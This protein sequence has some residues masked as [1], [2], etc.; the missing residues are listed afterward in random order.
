MRMMT[1][2][3]VMM[4]LTV[5]PGA[6]Q[7]TGSGQ[8]AG[9]ETFDLI[10]RNGTVIDGTGAEPIKADVAITGR[11]ILRI[12]DLTGQSAKREIN[13]TGL[14]VAPGFINLH[15]H[16]SPA[17]LSTAEN[18]LTQ[19]V[20]TEL[21]NADGALVAQHDSEPQGGTMPTIAWR[22]GQVVTDRH[23]I[24]LPDDLPPGD[25]TLIVGIYHRDAPNIRLPVGGDDYL[26]L[27]NITVE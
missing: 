7:P 3:A 6:S 8:A 15:S 24:A 16:A 5:Q 25:Y 22:P 27:S 13:A 4:A 11:N 21:L 10:I 12:G 1:A 20:T 23:G 2:T 26:E 19:G 9:S 18:M 14:Y 17:A